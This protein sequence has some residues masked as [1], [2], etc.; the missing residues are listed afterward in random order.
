MSLPTSEQRR[1]V[2]EAR[3]MTAEAIAALH[4]QIAAISATED[5]LGRLVHHGALRQ[6]EA[7]REWLEE[8]ADLLGAG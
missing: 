7:R 1:F 3:M 4:R 8:A 6:L 5:P 2:A